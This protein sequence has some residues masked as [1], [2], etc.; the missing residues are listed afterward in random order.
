MG[1]HQTFGK[2]METPTNER[3]RRYSFSWGFGVFILH[4]GVTVALWLIIFASGMGAFT[5][6][7]G[8]WFYGGKRIMWVWSPFAAAA[9]TGN[10]GTGLSPEAIALL[11]SLVVGILA[12]WIIPR[13]IKPKIHE[14]L[15]P[16]ANPDLV[17]TP[18]EQKTSVTFNTLREANKMKKPNKAEMATP[19]KP[20][21]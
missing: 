16:G 17:G 6:G 9:S 1:A 12:G 19:R 14:S 8:P 2:E 13:F 15:P 5:S 7:A 21:D 4:I 10:L 20:S 18:W 3:T 11:W